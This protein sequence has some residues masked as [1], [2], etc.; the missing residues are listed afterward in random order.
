MRLETQG[1]S[2]KGSFMHS[3][4]L[5]SDKVICL[6]SWGERP[7]K[8]VSDS[9]STTQRLGAFCGPRWWSHPLHNSNSA[10]CPKTVIS[11]DLDNSVKQGGQVIP[12]YQSHKWRH[13]D[14]R[15]GKRLK[16]GTKSR[17]A[18]SKP[19]SD[20]PWQPDPLSAQRHCG[21]TS[22]VLCPSWTPSAL[23]TGSRAPNQAS[24]L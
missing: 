11:S 4:C 19:Q 2:H 1:T 10:K 3:V 5:I 12:P 6:V 18:H 23:E 9:T 7:G 22:Q 20:P 14:F 8:T 24:L 16:F 13:G 21:P 15:E 17:T